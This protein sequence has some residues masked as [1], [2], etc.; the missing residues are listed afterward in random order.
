MAPQGEQQQQDAVTDD[1]ATTEANAA[2]VVTPSKSKK[3]GPNSD[4]PPIPVTILSGFLGS[5]KT[6]LLKHILESP[7]HGLRVAVI[8]NDMA[9]LNIDAALVTQGNVTTTTDAADGSGGESSSEK[10]KVVVQ[11]A[12]EII[13]LQNGC[14][15]CTLRGDLI[16]E[17]ARIRSDESS[18]FDY[19]LIESTGIAEP[20]AVAASFVFDPST[21]QLAESEEQMLWTQA[22]LDTCV[23]VIDAQMFLTQ[24]GTLAMFSDRFE[25][26]L[27]TSTPEGVKEGQK[28]IANLL[29]EQVEFADVILS[30]HDRSTSG[31]V[32][33]WLVFRKAFALSLITK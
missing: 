21:E 5:G 19:V 9:E 28:S 10:K 8:V 14:I 27:D 1:P 15:C 23:T 13:S 22:R 33:V 30:F 18:K 7:D 20:S 16:R 17:I 4:K 29:V 25:D 31:W 24:M 2:V 12:K 26:G 11:A 32:F 6:T 3:K